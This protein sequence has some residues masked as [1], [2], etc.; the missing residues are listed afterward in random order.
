[1]G[2]A[3]AFTV[4]PEGKSKAAPA[5]HSAD[6]VQA[7]Y[8]FGV[9]EKPLSYL[10]FKKTLKVEL[11]T[12]AKL[13]VGAYSV[14]D[15]TAECELKLKDGS[16]LSVTLM[17]AIQVDGKPATLVGLMGAVPAGYRVFPVHTFSNCQ[18]VA[19]HK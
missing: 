15:R 1:M 3:F 17:T 2:P 19:E 11:A 13:S 9:D 16:E 4:P 18:Q 12:I 6:L 7:L 8:K 10:T 5:V 14:K